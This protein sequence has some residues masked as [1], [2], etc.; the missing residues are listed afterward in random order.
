[1]TWSD[2]NNPRTLDKAI[3]WYGKLGEE[4]HGRVVRNMHLREAVPL[5]MGLQAVYTSR[6]MRDWGKIEKLEKNR[7]G[8]L[9]IRTDTGHTN[10]FQEF[11]LF[12][13]GDMGWLYGS[14]WL[15]KA[16]ACGMCK[17]ECKMPERCFLF[18][19]REL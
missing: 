16:G 15:I 2:A 4:Y 12:D 7:N 18:E 9:D 6:D 5:L 8:Y 13:N 3:F 1:M 10:Y 19:E 14:H 17:Y 11:Q